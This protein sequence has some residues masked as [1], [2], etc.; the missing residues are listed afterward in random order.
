MTTTKKSKTNR[1]YLI[2][3]IA[4][5]NMD[6]AHE[7]IEAGDANL[8]MRLAREAVERYESIGWNATAEAIRLQL[9]LD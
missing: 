9:D 5:G 3:E 1:V 6:A 7:A 4:K 2:A 8:A